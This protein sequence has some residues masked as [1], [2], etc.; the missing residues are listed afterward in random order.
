MSIYCRQEYFEYI[1]WNMIIDPMK[2]C[3]YKAR[4]YVKDYIML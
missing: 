2:N 3:K 1:D 4:V